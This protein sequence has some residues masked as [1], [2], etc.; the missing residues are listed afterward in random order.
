[1]SFHF[2]LVLLSCR[3]LKI[4]NWLTKVC[5][6]AEEIPH[7][8]ELNKPFMKHLLS[9]KQITNKSFVF[10]ILGDDFHK[11]EWF[12]YNSLLIFNDQ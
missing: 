11:I 2:V 9:L 3:L 10:Y 4:F 1:M 12:A 7:E 6:L 8:L 5:E